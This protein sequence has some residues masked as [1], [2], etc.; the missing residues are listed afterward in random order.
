M[1]S[2]WSTLSWIALSSRESYLSLRSIRALQSVKI[3][4]R[5]R[6]FTHHIF[7]R[8]EVIIPLTGFPV[9]PLSPLIPCI[10]SGPYT[11]RGLWYSEERGIELRDAYPISLW[12]LRS[13][14]SSLSTVTRES[15]RPLRPS[16]ARTTLLKRTR[17][18]KVCTG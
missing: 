16:R 11:H 4:S 6:A 8:Q 18:F 17:D 14:V 3:S 10:P 5:A 15:R 13:Q 12:S 9:S 2:W 1:L 7:L